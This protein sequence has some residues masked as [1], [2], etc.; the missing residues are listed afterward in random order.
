MSSAK[1]GNARSK[2][3]SIVKVA[4]AAVLGGVLWSLYK[5]VQPLLRK[6]K[7]SDYCIEK[8]DTL[9]SIAQRNGISVCE[10]KAANGYD[11]DD[12]YAGDIMRVP[13]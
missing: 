7:Y 2:D 9:F 1:P 10:L 13:K 5:S 8:G 6:P 4:G 3:R 11:S 12:I